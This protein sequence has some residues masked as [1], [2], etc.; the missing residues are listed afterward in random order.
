MYYSLKNII[1]HVHVY[2]KTEIHCKITCFQN[3]CL[4]LLY[5]WTSVNLMWRFVLSWYLLFFFFLFLIF[6]VVEQA[7]AEGG[8]AAKRAKAADGPVDVET[9]LLHP[10]CLMPP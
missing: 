3:G 5:K 6:A 9:T 2:P 1:K 8:G 4:C 7:P 10:F